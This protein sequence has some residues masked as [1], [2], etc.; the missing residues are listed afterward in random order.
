MNLLIHPLGISQPHL[1]PLNLPCDIDLVFI[2]LTVKGDED[3]ER[4]GVVGLE[5]PS[6]VKSPLVSDLG[7]TAWRL[8]FSLC[9]MKTPIA[10]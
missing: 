9:P 1:F 6:E 8:A 4:E 3:V 2:M 7:G 10:F 5:D